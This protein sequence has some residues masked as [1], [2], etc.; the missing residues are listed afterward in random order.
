MMLEEREYQ[1]LAAK[2]TIDY[3]ASGGQS[4]LTVGPPGCGKTE[5]EF[6]IFRMK[7]GRLLWVEH[8]RELAEQ[9]VMR[10]RATGFTVGTIMGG[11][12]EGVGENL[13]VATIQSLLN[14][15]PLDGFDIL[16][17]DEAHH[18]LAETWSAVRFKQPGGFRCIS[19][20]TATPERA[21]G[22][23]LGDMFEKLHVAAHYSELIRGGFI[24]K[25]NVV[26]PSRRLGRDWSMNPLDAW[27]SVGFGKCILYVPSI[28]QADEYAE[29]ANLRRL[30]AVAI[31]ENTKPGERAEALDSFELDTSTSVQLLVC[32]GTLLEGIDLRITRVVILG[33]SFVWGGGF[34]QAT[35]RV[36]RTHPTKDA[37][38]RRPIVIDLTGATLKHQHPTA[39]RI[40]SLE[41][42]AIMPG[43]GGGSGGCAPADPRVVDVAMIDDFEPG[44]RPKPAQLPAPD[45]RWWAREKK[46]RE[47]LRRRVARFGREVAEAS[48]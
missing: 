46:R 38:R 35:G 25:P 26:R 18:Y 22:E 17:L 19:G 40:Y 43:T 8:Q 1:T 48:L 15:A 36:L 32:V 3:W 28:Q 29:Q 10:A 33:R 6:E 16:H 5:I 24:L 47:R 39:D 42:R 37:H 31:T 4:A 11:H 44:L 23:P 20:A 12:N 7:G 27:A 30:R 21:S 34:L 14:H 2:A 41:G 13:V 45:Y 9:I